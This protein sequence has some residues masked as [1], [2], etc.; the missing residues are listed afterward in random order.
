MIKV[1]LVHFKGNL[2]NRTDME[3]VSDKIESLTGLE[4]SCDEEKQRISISRAETGS[5]DKI[6][7]LGE[8]LKLI[9]DWVNIAIEK[10]IVIVIYL[11]Q[12][13]WGD[14]YRELYKI[15]SIFIDE[16]PLS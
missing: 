6:V 5:I 16:E 4:T 9:W 14:V 8:V 1:N 12:G 13:D 11:D 15:Q 7:S 10:E 2:N 3:F